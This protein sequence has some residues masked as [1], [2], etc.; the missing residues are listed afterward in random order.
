ME[1]K[2]HNDL[3]YTIIFYKYTHNT[4]SLN[5]GQIYISTFSLTWISIPL[6]PLNFILLWYSFM[7][8]NLY[9]LP[10][11]AF[12]QKNYVYWL[13]ILFPV[14]IRL[15]EISLYYRYNLN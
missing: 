3:T 15:L 12:L 9:C 7:L 11:Y 1:L 2:Y 14:T 8:E 13:Q 5:I 10:C 6:L 4:P